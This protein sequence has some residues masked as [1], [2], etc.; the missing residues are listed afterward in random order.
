MEG[1][2]LQEIYFYFDDSGVFTQNNNVPYFVYGGIYFLDS[3]SRDSCKNKYKKIS[4]QIKNHLCIEGELKACKIKN[5]KYKNA[6]LRVSNSYNT[7]SLSVSLK[8]IYPNILG[9]K[10]SIHR[11]KDYVLK[12]IVKKVLIKEINQNNINPTK[13]TKLVICVDEQAT[14]TNGY[15]DLKSSIY[16]EL[17]FGISNFDYGVRHKNIFY[18]DLIV[19]VKYCDSATNWLIQLSDI[20]ANSVWSAYAKKEPLLMDT[21]HNHIHMTFPVE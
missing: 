2:K 20:I 14:S 3:K 9:N 15:Y 13:P 18:S 12:R 19:E 10:K 5:R 17:R 1:R 8:D 4:K 6:L 16:E 21:F 7:M 11:Y